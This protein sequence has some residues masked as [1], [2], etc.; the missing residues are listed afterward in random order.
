MT[1]NYLLKSTQSCRF[2]SIKS[3]NIVKYNNSHLSSLKAYEA[4][5]NTGSDLGCDGNSMNAETFKG[6]TDNGSTDDIS[7]VEPPPNVQDLKEVDVMEHSNATDDNSTIDLMK[8]EPRELIQADSNMGATGCPDGSDGIPREL[9]GQLNYAKHEVELHDDKA[10]DG[11]QEDSIVEE[12][13]NAM[14]ELEETNRELLGTS[15]EL[16]S[17]CSPGIEQDVVPGKNSEKG[18]CELDD[19]FEVGCVL[20]EYGRTEAS[21]MAAHCLH[22]RYFDERIVVTGYAALDL[23]RRKFPR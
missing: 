11:S 8:D 21:C 19:M 20:V 6:G 5:D 13:S 18:L 2:G 23:Y 22:G 1:S 4:G 12:R 17:S 9:P 15:A 10:A 3:V 14:V 16:D 7:G